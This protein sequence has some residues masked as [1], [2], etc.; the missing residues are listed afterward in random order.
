M[1]GTAGPATLEN[2]NG[3][4]VYG[5]TITNGATTT[6]VKV[7]AGNGKVLAQDSGADEG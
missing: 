7:D 2:E 6:D 1:P 3:N 4:V 5:V